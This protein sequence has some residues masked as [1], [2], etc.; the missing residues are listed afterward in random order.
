MAP[1]DVLALRTAGPRAHGFGAMRRPYHGVARGLK[2]LFVSPAY[3]T[4]QAAQI[5]MIRSSPT[6]FVDLDRLSAV[7]RQAIAHAGGASDHDLLNHF[8][9]DALKALGC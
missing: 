3:G 6:L 2:V 8:L 1:A 4:D 9:I 7:G 5:G